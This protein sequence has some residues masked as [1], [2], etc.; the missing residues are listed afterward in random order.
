MIGVVLGNGPSKQLYDRGGDFVIGC[1]IPTKEFSVDATVICDVEVV[2]ILKSNPALMDDTPLIIST[3]VFEKMKELKIVDDY[4]ILDVFKPRDWYNSGHYAAQYL[5][6]NGCSD[7]HIWGCDSI[8]ESTLDSSTD[9]HIEKNMDKERFI[10]NWRRVWED[11]RV[12]N[13]TTN[14]VAIRVKST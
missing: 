11:I 10:K 14:F 13:P 4:I 5:I 12:N 7:V 8:F 9:Q 6:D 3:N 1:N 2:W